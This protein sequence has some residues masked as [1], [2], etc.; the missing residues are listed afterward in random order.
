M[1]TKIKQ[2]SRTDKG[3]V[4]FREKWLES[5]DIGQLILGV[6]RLEKARDYFIKP[7]VDTITNFGGRVHPVPQPILR[8]MTT[9][10]RRSAILLRASTYKPSPNGTSISVELLDASSFLT[11]E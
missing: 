10:L 9:E 3:A 1:D 4:S 7:L 8:A 11:K 6:R 5:N 2:F